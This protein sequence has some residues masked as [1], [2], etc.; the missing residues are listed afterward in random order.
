MPR[1]L[2]ILAL[3]ALGA[4]P[5]AAQAHPHMFIDAG[6]ELVFDDA[7]QLA[8]VRVVWAY[9][10]FYS[11]IALS[12]MGLDAA[13][14]G[15]LT[16]EER[17]ALQGFDM[18]W[19]EGFDGDIVVHLDG[20]VQDLAGPAD[21]TADYV[22]G[23]IISSHLRPLED[24][25]HLPKGAELR[26][27]VYDSTYYTAYTIVGTP[28]ITGRDGCNARVFTPDREAADAQLMAALS[29]LEGTGGDAEVDFPAVGEM[30][31]EEVRVTCAAAS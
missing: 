18:Q 16:A 6:L 12:D 11:M 4:T 3:A 27:Q 14:S 8:A 19:I 29:E 28:Q 23:R 17:A 5:V 10:A 25:A 1:A 22:D 15:T 30:F 13:F 24:R 9:D 26:I 20:V 7:D 2:R 31:S 21:W